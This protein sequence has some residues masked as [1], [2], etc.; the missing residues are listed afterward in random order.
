[1]R[2]CQI[3]FKYK[4]NKMV[5][6]KCS[7]DNFRDFNKINLDKSFLLKIKHKAIRLKIWYRLNNIEKTIYGNGLKEIIKIANSLGNKNSLKWIRFLFNIY[8]S[9]S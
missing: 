3:G 5:M 1:M 8:F 2:L 4:E 6:K 9:Y 7:S